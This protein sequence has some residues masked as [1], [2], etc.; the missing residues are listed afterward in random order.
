MHARAVGFLAIADGNAPAVCGAVIVIRAIGAHVVEAVQ[1]AAV[2]KRV[3]V[4]LQQC[5]RITS[6]RSDICRWCSHD[7]FW[8]SRYC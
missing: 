5:T 7:S 2:L 1:V 8:R 6:G 3:L 4:Q